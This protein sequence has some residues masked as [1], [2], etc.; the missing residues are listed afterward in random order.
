MEL[1]GPGQTDRV[2]VSKARVGEMKLRGN[3]TVGREKHLQHMDD[4][5]MVPYLET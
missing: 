3:S 5:M 1:L 2:G 4:R